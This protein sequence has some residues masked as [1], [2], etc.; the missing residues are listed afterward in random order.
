MLVEEWRERTVFSDL[1][2]YLLFPPNSCSVCGNSYFLAEKSSSDMPRLSPIVLQLIYYRR[3]SISVW[4]HIPFGTSIN[5]S[6]GCRWFPSIRVKGCLCERLA[7]RS[8]ESM[9]VIDIKVSF[10]RERQR[11]RYGNHVERELW[12]MIPR[13]INFRWTCK[14]SFTIRVLL[15]SLCRTEIGQSEKVT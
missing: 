3:L 9:N 6:W 4:N 1:V 10:K 8:V 13:R 7:L 15:F 12:E 11:R 2:L 5:N 14:F